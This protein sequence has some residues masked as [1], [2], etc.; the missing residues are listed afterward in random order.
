MDESSVPMAP[1]APHPPPVLLSQEGGIWAELHPG[2]SEHLPVEQEVC[3]WQSRGLKLAQ[4]E[5][6]LVYRGLNFLLARL[7]LTSLDVMEQDQAEMMS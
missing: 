1:L 5:F 4:T 6:P 2:G 7:L 3:L